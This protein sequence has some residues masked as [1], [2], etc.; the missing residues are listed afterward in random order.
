[1]AMR[2]ETHPLEAAYA[3]LLIQGLEG[4]GEA[5]RILV[6]EASKIERAHQPPGST[7]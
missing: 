5:L 6:N 2:V 1:M 7:L 3:A 4:A